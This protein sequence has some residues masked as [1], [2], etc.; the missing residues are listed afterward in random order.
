PRLAV[1]WP[2]FGLAAVFVGLVGLTLA[3][4]CLALY[5]RPSGSFDAYAIWNLRARFILFSPQN[6]TLAF[7][8]LISWKAHVDYP[9]LWPMNMLRM[10]LILGRDS[11][12]A[13][14]VQTALFFVLIPGLLV[15]GLLKL[16][17]RSQAFLGGILILGMPAF[18]NYSTFQ[19]AD[20][21]LAYFYMATLLLFLG[22]E[23]DRSPGLLALAGL[24]TGLAGWTKN[25]GLMFE[26]GV[27]VYLLAR[28]LRPPF[29]ASLRKLGWFGLGLALPLATTLIFKILLAPA[30]DLIGTQ[31][32]GEIMAKL[33]DPSRYATIVAYVASYLP[34]L[35]GWIWPMA[36][37]VPL[38]GLAAGKAKIQPG[39]LVFMILGITFLG[40]FGVYLITP[41]PLEWHLKYSFDRLMFQLLIP[42]LFLMLALI[43]SPNDLISGLVKPGKSDF[44][45]K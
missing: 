10:W 44:P 35:G 34:N 15:G 27:A 36:A 41:H 25:E 1:R 22:Y 11:V 7:S 20:T 31:N 30:G 12:E 29:R 39:W 28:F 32:A 23:R 18:F 43:R 14:I 37:A 16:R 5:M 6:W 19:A 45:A 9:L 4:Y 42:A 33:L 40:Y 3:A 8:P 24:A 13:G 17:D 2:L 26:I 21:P 38:Y